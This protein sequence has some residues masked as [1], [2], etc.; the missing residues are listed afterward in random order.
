MSTGI[1]IERR[2]PSPQV[3]GESGFSLIELLIA[4]VCT[5]FVGGAVMAMLVAGNS[6]FRR[7]PA[8]SDRQQNIRVA[9]DLIQRD[10]SIAGS[11]M[12]PFVQ[13]FLR[14]N[15]AGTL[16]D[17]VG[18]VGPD[19][20]PSDGLTIIGNPGDCPSI[21]ATGP[22]GVVVNGNRNLPACYDAP[23]LV[24]LEGVRGSALPYSVGF[25]CD[26]PAANVI[27]FPP[28][29]DREHNLPRAGNLPNPTLGIQAIQAVSYII[30]VDPPPLGDNQTPNL[31]RSPTGGINPSGTCGVGGGGG[32]GT[33]GY[34]LVARGIE[35]LQVWYI[36]GDAARTRVATPPV[37]VDGNFDTVVRE[38]EITLTARAMG[39]AN[40]HG[41]TDPV[42]GPRVGFPRA[43]R[44]TL[45]SVTTPRAV[46]LGMAAQ[47]PTPVWK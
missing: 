16:L 37:A 39:D 10:V 46:L 3:D 25:A 43:V 13:A 19:N 47:T 29:Q 34:E 15:L 24:Y 6:A 5:L 44:Q 7:E 12:D 20:I 8:L 11:E 42:G 4:I 45:R 32:G 2:D 28:G 21:P 22:T 30:R 14:D 18:P 41:A 36:L 27:N 1:E 26:P 17:G 40:L 35:D 33:D 9:M 31:W 38:V 23:A